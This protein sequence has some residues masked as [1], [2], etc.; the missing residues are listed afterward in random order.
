MKK[1]ACSAKMRNSNDVLHE[2]VVHNLVRIRYRRTLTDEQYCGIS[3][4]TLSG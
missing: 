4:P 2:A 1:I 3:S